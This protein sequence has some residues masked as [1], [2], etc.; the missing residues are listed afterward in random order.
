[1][2]NPQSV[3][4]TH[5]P[6]QTSPETNIA[7]ADPYNPAAVESAITAY[8]GKHQN[9]TK[10]SALLIKSGLFELLT[11]GVIRLKTEAVPIELQVA[12]FR[13]YLLLKNWTREQA[14]ELEEEYADLAVEIHALKEE[15]K[16][17][18]IELD[19][20]RYPRTHPV[21]APAIPVGGVTITT[22]PAKGTVSPAPSAVSVKPQPKAHP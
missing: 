11:N 4:V 22:L 14:G 8:L 20:F 6:A 5:T 3:A 9:P 1:M 21:T 15:R 19:E 7:E 16:L 17:L 18:E 10:I 2:E 13:D 12:F